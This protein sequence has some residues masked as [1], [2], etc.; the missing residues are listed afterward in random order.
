MGCGT[1]KLPKEN[2]G[3]ITIS[4]ENY[5]KRRGCPMKWCKRAVAVFLMACGLSVSCVA[6]AA[7]ELEPPAPA[8][9]ALEG[10]GQVSPMADRLV[11][12][13]GISQYG[14]SWRQDVGY[15][16]YRVWVHNTTEYTMDVTI[17]APNG[18]KR[19]F[20]VA[21]GGNKSYPVN[22]V[23]S[24]VYKLSFYAGGHALSGTVR[25]RVSDMTLA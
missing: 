22:G 11:V 4:V 16:S 8:T 24:G 3:Q 12:D 18:G 10:G 25:V 2:C 5:D 20:Q 6:G 19:T 7:G 1:I 13:V 9:M 17:T 15:T 21:A 23:P 14:V